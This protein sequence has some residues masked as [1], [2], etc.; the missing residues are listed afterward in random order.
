MLI[1]MGR[2]QKER[3]GKSLADVQGCTNIAVAGCKG[4]M[5]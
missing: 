2:N 4:V 3:N 1:I 5:L